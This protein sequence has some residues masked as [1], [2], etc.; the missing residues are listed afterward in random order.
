MLDYFIDQSDLLIGVLYLLAEHLV[1]TVQQE[2][3]FEQL[4]AKVPKAHLT[5]TFQLDFIGE[6]TIQVIPG[7]ILLKQEFDKRYIRQGLGHL[8]LKF[9][10]S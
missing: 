3:I 7:E 10:Q 8:F 1:P 9:K 4:R 2:L 5:H 6:G